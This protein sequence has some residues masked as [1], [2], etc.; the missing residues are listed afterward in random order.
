MVFY[1]CSL[2]SVSNVSISMELSGH[3]R[4]RINNVELTLNE[5]ISLEA[6]ELKLR[7]QC[8]LVVAGETRVVRCSDNS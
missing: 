4:I 1:V 2:C 8:W 3:I 6:I 5:M 7:A